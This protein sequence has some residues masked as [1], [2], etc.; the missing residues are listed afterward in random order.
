M[1]DGLIGTALCAYVPVKDSEVSG[2]RN[3]KRSRCE[4]RKDRNVGR[5]LGWG[6][7]RR[8]WSMYIAATVARI[9]LIYSAI[10]VRVGMHLDVSA[11]CF[12]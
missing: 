5:D 10:W 1:H 8:C 11:R 12:G 2:R 9:L 3:T 6:A 7:C 4:T